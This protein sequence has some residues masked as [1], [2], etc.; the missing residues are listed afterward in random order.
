M[1]VEHDNH[2]DRNSLFIDSKVTNIFI[3][4]EKRKSNRTDYKKQNSLIFNSECLRCETVGN[5]I[6][7]NRPVKRRAN[8]QTTIDATK[9]QI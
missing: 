8:K 6:K 5:I 4:L 3:I 7:T 1:T 9:Q 2:I